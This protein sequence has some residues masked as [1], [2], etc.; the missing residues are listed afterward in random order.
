MGIAE[1]DLDSRARI[2]ALLPGAVGR[3]AG[4]ALAV[5]AIALCFKSSPASRFRGGAT[6]AVSHS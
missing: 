1:N 3:M 5:I 4:A 2:A 6:D